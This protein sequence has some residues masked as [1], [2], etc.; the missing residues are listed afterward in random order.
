MRY[1][2]VKIKDAPS[3]FFATGGKLCSM[4]G[5]G[6]QC[7]PNKTTSGFAPGRDESYN[8]V[9]RRIALDSGFTIAAAPT[10]VKVQSPSIRKRNAQMFFH[11]A[12]KMHAANKKSVHF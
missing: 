11:V 6:R 7:H 12:E 1:T 4:G 8:K 5:P 2:Q 3:I 9:T 10:A